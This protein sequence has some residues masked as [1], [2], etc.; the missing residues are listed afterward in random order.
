MQDPSLPS[1]TSERVQLLQTVH[2]NHTRLS[3]VADLKASILIGSSL[4]VLTL[5]FSKLDTENL[6]ITLVVLAAFLLASSAFAVFATL[7]RSKPE[8]GRAH[9]FNLF[10]FGSFA[11][12]S[13]REFTTSLM[14]T[15]ADEHKALETMCHDIYQL[16]AFLYLRKFRFLRWSYAILLAGLAATSITWFI[17]L[18]AG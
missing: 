16:G 13:E 8:A 6:S 2:Q 17:E 9:K 12:L 11:Q 3:A 5:I 10:F 7:P 18:V 1:L 14:D 4:I 15:L